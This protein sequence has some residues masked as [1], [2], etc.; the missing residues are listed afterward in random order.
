M[1]RRLARHA[2]FRRRARRAPR[3]GAARAEINVSIVARARRIAAARLTLKCMAIKRHETHISAA[4][5]WR[6]RLIEIGIIGMPAAHALDVGEA[7]S[8]DASS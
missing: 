2:I 1:H 3:G 7:S 8:L 6:A 5:Q 4:H